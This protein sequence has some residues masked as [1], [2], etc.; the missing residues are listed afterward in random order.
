MKTEAKIRQEVIDE[1][2]NKPHFT[3]FLEAVKTEMAHHEQ[4][5]GDE[6][7]T[8]PHHFQMVLGFIN[9]KLAKAIWE[10]DTEKFV[11]HLITIA[12]VAGTAHKYFESESEIS[13][14][15]SGEEKKL[16]QNAT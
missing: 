1:L 9:G 3:N 2:I 12:A 5:W 8:P 7:A 16:K 10:K 14:W 11:H 6:T 15:F 4:R 13:K